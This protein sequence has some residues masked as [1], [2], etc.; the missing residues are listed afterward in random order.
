MVKGLKETTISNID[1]G[2]V[3]LTGGNIWRQSAHSEGMQ[4][5]LFEQHKRSSS[6][7]LQKNICV[8][9]KMKSTS[10]A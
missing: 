5:N 7:V 8:H 2:R 1:L 9:N 6:K 10:S 3:E 4:Y